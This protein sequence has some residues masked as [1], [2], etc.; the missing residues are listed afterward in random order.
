MTPEE[1]ILLELLVDI[2]KFETK[3]KN[4]NTPPDIY[5]MLSKLRDRTAKWGVEE[6]VKGRGK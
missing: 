4:L 1:K 6:I 3:C 2:N 5:K